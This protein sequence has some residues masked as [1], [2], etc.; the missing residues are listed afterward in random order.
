MN[1]AKLVRARESLVSRMFR[2]FTTFHNLGYIPNL[3]IDAALAGLRN[4]VAEAGDFRPAVKKRV[5]ADLP[6]MFPG[7]FRLDVNGF[8]SSG[9]NSFVEPL[10]RPRL[11][12]RFGRRSVT[13][14]IA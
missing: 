12:C 5:L 2:S 13:I 14:C 11:V 6:E 4:C 10:F 9:K 3:N 8:C 1:V 7:K